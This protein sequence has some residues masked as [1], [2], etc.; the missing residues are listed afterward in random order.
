MIVE[1]YGKVLGRPGLDAGDVRELCIVALLAVAGRAAQLYSH[2]RG[3][4]NAGARR[5]RSRKRWSCWNTRRARP[6][7]RPARSGR[8]SVRLAVSRRSGR[9]TGD[10]RDLA[11]V[12]RL[13]GNARASA[14]RAVRARR[15][16]GA[17]WAW[18]SAGRRAG[19]AGGAGTCMLRADPQLCDAA[20]LPLPAAL[21]RGAG[22]AWQGKNRTGQGRRGPGAAGAGRHRGEGRGDGRAAGRDDG[23]GAGDRGGEGRSRRAWQRGI[24]H[25]DAAG[26][27]ALGAGRRGRGAPHRAGAEADRGRRAGGPAERG[28]VHVA[29]GVSAATPKIAD[30]PFTTLQPNLGVV[31]LLDH[32]TFVLADIPGIIEGAHE[33]KGLGLRFLRHI[34]RTRTLAFLIPRGRG[35]PAGRVRDAAQ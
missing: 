34:E 9:H 24:R 1:G 20:R 11:D 22:P 33:G 30:Y 3:A 5:R 4:L 26:A 14:G 17:R 27:A 16:S 23:A 6:R 15:R 32:R 21:P 7:M 2:L 10:L 18:R 28:Q 29:R 19:T 13:C 12:R 35:G 25:G 8:T 31:P